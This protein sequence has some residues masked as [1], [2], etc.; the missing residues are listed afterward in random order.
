MK[1][2]NMINMLFKYFYN[3]FKINVYY[4]SL[5]LNNNIIHLV[6]M[7][8]LIRIGVFNNMTFNASYYVVYKSLW[9][10]LE[11]VSLDVLNWIMVYIFGLFFIYKY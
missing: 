5:K 11:G 7:F 10:E 1:P 6:N 3:N 2:Q 4:I 8:N 9:L